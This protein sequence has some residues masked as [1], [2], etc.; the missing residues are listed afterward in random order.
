[1]PAHKTAA[2]PKTVTKAKEP[3][4][5]S[6]DIVVTKPAPLV[7]AAPLAIEGFA[8]VGLDMLRRPSLIITQDKTDVVQEKI[9][10]PGKLFVKVYNVDLGTEAEITVLGTS[11]EYIL[12]NP[13]RGV[14]P[15]IFAKSRDR[16]NWDT[17][18]MANATFEANVPNVGKVKWL[19]KGDVAESGLLKTGTF[20]PGNSES[21]PALAD[22]WNFLVHIHG[23]EGVLPCVL[24]LARGHFVAAS[25]LLTLITSLNRKSPIDPRRL[26]IKMKVAE[27]TRKGSTDKY[28]SVTFRPAGLLGDDEFQQMVAEAD[29]Y[30]G[31]VVDYG[32]AREDDGT[33]PA[34]RDTSGVTEY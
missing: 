6:T 1:M 23:T 4:M 26:R 27:R 11:H 21:K 34:K 22:T 31:F 5:E 25:N 3:V 10:E 24:S 28:H 16:V 32:A 33:A 13:V 8:D 19:T 18:E 7:V 30:R 14:D 20:A 9:V 12:Y 17:P 15:M 2:K 29:Q